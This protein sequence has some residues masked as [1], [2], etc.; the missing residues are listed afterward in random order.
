MKKNKLS[1]SELSV[2][3]FTTS[4]PE[5]VKGGTGSLITRPI[6]THQGICESV[7]CPTEY[8]GCV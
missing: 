3:S 2:K 1:L 5:N 7:M 6:C 8:H 4:N